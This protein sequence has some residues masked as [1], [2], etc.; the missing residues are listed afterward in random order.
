MKVPLV[1]FP[2]LHTK[3]SS[4]FWF[5]IIL[6]LVLLAACGGS[7]TPVSV[8]LQSQT[9]AF[10]SISAQSAGGSVTLS[11]TASSGL[12]VS[13]ASN[14]SAVCTVS[15]NLANLV[16]SGTCTIQASQAGDSAYAA[17]I[18]VAQSFSVALQSQ[19]IDFNSISAQFAGGS[20]AL[21]ATATSG[22]AVSFSSNTSEVCTVSGS[23]ANLLAGG[24]CTIQASQSGNSVYGAA[25]PVE[26]SFS[27]TEPLP[28]ISGISPASA[29]AGDAGLSLT[30][31]GTGFTAA[32]TAT[33]AG[34]A[35]PITFV[36]ANEVTVALS[37]S[38]L[39]F[40][41]IETLLISNPS[42]GGG[43]AQA[44]VPILTDVE[45]SD[46]AML[47]R[48]QLAAG[49]QARMERVLE[50]ARSGSPVTIAAIGGSIT[51]GFGAS[52][53]SLS[54]AARI[55]A[56]WGHAFPGSAAT[57]VNAGV[58]GTASD[59]GSLRVQRDVLSKNPDLVIVEFAVNDSSDYYARFYEG[60]LR[61]VLDAPSQPAVMLLFMMKYEMPVVEADVT[62][63]PWQSQIG[64]QY[65]VPMVSYFDAIAPAIDSGAIPIATLS[66]DNTHPDD[67]GHAYAAQFLEESLIAANAN[68]PLGST[69]E[70]IP[71]T[72]TPLYSGDFEF[73]TLQDGATLSPSNNQGWTA[74]PGDSDPTLDDPDAG[75]QS[76]TPGSTLDFTVTGKEI[77]M[78]YWVFDGPMGQASV[79]VDGSST[80]VI[81][82]GWYDKTSGGY[83][84][85]D[86]VGDGL[87]SGSHQ[88]HV[89]LLTTEDSGS[90]GN[91]F[92]LLCIGTG[93]A[94]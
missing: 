42:P 78:G 64:A 68:F 56:W 34:V 47:G 37:A 86:L 17:A 91:L 22:L 62:A 81:L 85:I 12:A 36:S 2:R 59:Y 55:A 76:S 19:T 92:R 48:S 88:V 29:T 27:V 84:G 24:T 87:N 32:T 5:A 4:M 45:Q 6:G 66:A 60:L 72:A 73:T 28:A 14:T 79:T 63:E 21:S 31:N 94:Q 26:Q 39:A 65:G 52:D 46:S 80:P 20:V 53:V 8:A 15:G 41:A 3:F 7:H 61:Q 9:I 10:N 69:L 70:N 58:G 89:E 75:L 82:D 25:T 74:E 35:H 30:V 43:T 51:V 44:T 71:S 40:P 90:T 11:A 77:L 67:L 49:N 57:L 18:P 50:K 1:G 13:F 23:V 33:F 93:G 83:R 16:A 54:Y 38:D